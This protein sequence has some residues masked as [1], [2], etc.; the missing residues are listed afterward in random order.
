MKTYRFFLLSFKFSVLAF[1]AE[2]IFVYCRVDSTRL[3]EKVETIVADRPD[4]ALL[5]LAKI[6]TTGLRDVDKARTVYLR[7]RASAKAGLPVTW[8]EEMCEAAEVLAEQTSDHDLQAMAYYYAG[9]AC[10]KND[11]LAAAVREYRHCE[12]ILG[13]VPSKPLFKY[14]QDALF[15]CYYDQSLYEEAVACLQLKLHAAKMQRDTVGIIDATNAIAHINMIQE[16]YNSALQYYSQSQHLLAHCSHKEISLLSRC[17]NGKSVVLCKLGLLSESLL[18]NDTAMSFTVDQA[19]YCAMCL[20][21]GDCYQELGMVDSA[22]HYFNL[23][24]ASSN[25]A[26]KN[27]VYYRLYHLHKRLGN[28]SIANVYADS[29][30]YYQHRGDARWQIKGIKHSDEEHL[31][32]L[33]EEVLQKERG[34]FKIAICIVLIFFVGLAGYL[35]WQRRN[36]KKMPPPSPIPDHSPAI[37]ES[38]TKSLENSRKAFEQTVSYSILKELLQSKDRKSNVEEQ[39]SCREELRTVLLPVI[40]RLQEIRCGITV[41]DSLFLFLCYMK[42][43]SSILI[44]YLGMS[45]RALIQRKYRLKNKMPGDLYELFFK[46]YK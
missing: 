5:A 25:I 4:E 42:I 19:Q 46:D 6:D 21:R 36:R 17:Y 43:P 38:L 44:R 45:D 28:D 27:G 41:D 14:V 39:E 9:Y 7:T 34:K 13:D 30:L 24:L 8:P 32:E 1:V 29:S 15:K 23:S 22:V 10:F 31:M 11:D 33:H 3:L 18:Y 16:D 20:N 2:G 35:V 26:L 40:S 37:P 12:R